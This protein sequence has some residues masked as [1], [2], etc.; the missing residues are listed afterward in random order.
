MASELRELQACCVWQVQWIGR[1]ILSVSD[2][3]WQKEGYMSL[4]D[5]GGCGTWHCP[6]RE[7]VH[8]VIPRVTVYSLY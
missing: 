5:G 2:F 4:I 8:Q 7:L 3:V 6:R 1:N